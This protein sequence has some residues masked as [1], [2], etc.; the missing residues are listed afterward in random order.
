M[1]SLKKSFMESSTHSKRNR[2]FALIVTLSLMILLTVIAVGLLTLSSISLRTSSQGAA[3]QTARANAKVALMLAIGDL[4]KQLGPDTRIS[5]TADQISNSD[6]T[7]STTPQPQRQWTG[8]Y[9]SWPADRPSAD[10][11]ASPD[12]LQWFISGDPSKIT[13]KDYA[14]SAPAADS[15]EIVSAK[16]VGTGDTVRVPRISQSVNGAR[17]TFAWWVGD[18]GVKAYVP[19]DPSPTPNGSSDQRL[20]MQAAPHFGLEMMTSDSDKPFADIDHESIDNEKL[21][22]LQQA[23]FAASPPAAVKP[24]FHD[25]TTQNRGLLTN[26]R[27]GGFRKDLS[28]ILQASENK[29]PT[30]PLYQSSGKDGINMA[31]LWAYQNLWTQLKN[32]GGTYTSGGTIPASAS[33]L[34]QEPTLAAFKGDMFYQHK[35]PVFIRFQQLLS[36]LA[37]PKSPATNPPSYELGIVIDPIV[38][39]WNPLDVPLSLQ[40]SF[41]S[42][43]Y[44]ALPYDLTINYKGVDTQIS[45]GKIIGSPSTSTGG[46]FLSMRIGNG[47]TPL[48]LKP[49]EVMTFSQKNAATVVGPLGGGAQQIEAEPGW[50]YDATG[51][52]FYYP[53]S[54]YRAASL[55]AGPTSAIFSY[56]VS[57][58]KDKSLGTAYASA[59]NIYYKYDRST[60]GE[61]LSVGYYT[62]N[63][64]IT[65]NDPKYLSFF[66]R[67]TPS[68]NIQLG[69]LTSKRPFMIFSFS[70]KTEEGSE[71]PGRFLA[72]YN[73]RAIKMD[74][75]DLEQNEQRAL[76][77]EIRTQAVTSVVGMDQTVG[78]AQANGT[79]YFGGGWT[80]EFGSS[81]VITHSIPRQAPVSLAAF[82]HSM[83]NGFPAA[84][85]GRITNNTNN[86]LLP[87]ISH[88]IGNSM[89]CSLIAPNATSGE[90]GGSRPLADHSYLANQ[91]LWDDYFLSGISPQTATVFDKTRDQREVA[92]DFLKG[93]KSLPVKFYKP[94]LTGRDPA[95]LLTELVSGSSVVPGAENI[96]ASLIT[97]EGLFNV[98]STSVEAWKAM[99]GSLR[100]R[101]ITGISPLGAD[102]IVSAGGETPIASL[103][104]PANAKVSTSGGTLDTE[105]NEAQW[106]G[107]HLISD[108]QIEELARAIVGQIRQRGPFLS[109]ADFVNRRVGSDKKLAV[110][111][112]IQSA[113]DDDSVSI[114]EPFRTGERATKGSED[115]LLFPEAER[116]AAAYGIPG[117][118]K[119]ADILT[120]IAPLLSARSDTFTIRG[121]GEKTNAAGT[122][123]IASAC[124]EAVIQRSAN[125]VDGSDE[126]TTP[127]DQ[128]DPV[129]KKF[130]RRF[131]IVS[132]RWLSSSE[133]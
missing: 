20:A 61:S 46:N 115:G 25:I 38:T 39:V 47:S 92:E 67:I 105:T 109:L 111:G 16:S 28:M 126:L 113:L 76:P 19:S 69:S 30:D 121:Y 22:S 66:D 93:T 54:K 65:A 73:P 12:F 3:M 42:I 108:D 60:D 77:F 44:F 83:A 52:G 62:I 64:K 70:A 37:K 32:G 130:G 8:A 120:P 13:S 45:L 74:F 58:N 116:G 55:V 4:Q 129:N 26:V 35:Q 48:V 40:G 86:F 10:R 23:S 106:S 85:N 1:K 49:G 125:F 63:N 81:R 33:Y 122:V 107:I 24:L 51:G 101:D 128:L 95:D 118:V 5:A 29:I 80:P 114:N 89:A 99:L 53:F 91:A 50:V 21:I 7:D 18:E 112:A 104:T 15:V 68:S 72:R 123:V 88:A 27:A 36:F 96:T 11:P 103:L 124:C 78:Q 14:A 34:E 56:S 82:Q 71:N 117:Y 41:A 6:P 133:I 87:Q 31:E 110:S 9:N 79:S 59:N 43:K 75:F 127:I 131:E 94:N 119:Q 102:S 132:F 57:P 90:L 97:V 17:N 100:N 84:S 2:G 98:N